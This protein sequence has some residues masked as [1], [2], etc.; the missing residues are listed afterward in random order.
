MKTRW[1]RDPLLWTLGACFAL[2]LSGYAACR[3]SHA[4]VHVRLQQYVATSAHRG[5]V[6]EHR[7]VDAPDAPLGAWTR[8]LWAPLCA[9][10]LALHRKAEADAR[11]T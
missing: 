5:Y 10:E 3:A 9:A 7:I 11:E 1:L 6:V 2:Y 4:L 8:T